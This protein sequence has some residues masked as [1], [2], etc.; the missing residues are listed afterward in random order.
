MWEA[1][2][3]SFSS[4][5]KIYFFYWMQ[6]NVSSSWN[7]LKFSSSENDTVTRIVPKP[8]IL[9][10]E[11]SGLRRPKFDKVMVEFSVIKKYIYMH[12]H[13]LFK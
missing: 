7:L 1:W 8:Q 6:D 11:L 9:E 13:T 10:W 3:K 5:V 2:N 12:I 4:A